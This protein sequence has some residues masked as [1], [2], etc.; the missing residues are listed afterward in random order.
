MNETDKRRT[1][2][3]DESNCEEEVAALLGWSPA[4]LLRAI[5]MHA[6]EEDDDEDVDKDDQTPPHTAR[7]TPSQT[8]IRCSPTQPWTEIGAGR[9]EQKTAET[10]RPTQHLHQHQQSR[11]PSAV[12]CSPPPLVGKHVVIDLTDSPSPPPTLPHPQQQQQRQRHK[13][14]RAPPSPPLS[15]V[16]LDLS[17]K[18]SRYSLVDR[19]DN[20]KMKCSAQRESS[21][22][23]SS[24]SSS[25]GSSGNRNINN[26]NTGLYVIHS[27]PLIDLCRPADYITVVMDIETTGFSPKT[28]HIIQLAA[29]ANWIKPN[30]LWTS[31]SFSEYVTLPSPSSASSSSRRRKKALPHHITKLTGITSK[32]LQTKGMAFD[33]MWRKF[34]SWLQA[35]A[36]HSPLSGDQAKPIV[37]LAHNGK[38]FDF[39]FLQAALE[40]FQ[41][42]PNDWERRANICCF[43]DTLLILRCEAAWVTESAINKENEENDENVA[44]RSAAVTVTDDSCD[45]YQHLDGIPGSLKSNRHQLR[46]TISPAPPSTAPQSTTTR[47]HVPVVVSKPAKLSLGALH[48]HLFHCEI[49]GAHCAQADVLALCRVLGST[50]LRHTWQAVGNSLQFSRR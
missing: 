11:C 25:N 35:C 40:R 31:D 50:S 49:S 18:L 42:Y 43:L 15:E 3:K 12:R 24:S 32:T 28:D 30:G 39:P 14:S 45:T 46:A 16:M 44:R 17:T 47:S 1:K 2:K 10:I 9:N 4:S 29:R 21:S 33:Q 23:S 41:L 48:E 36:G 26:K 19:N 13:R 37:L 6:R 20:N 38:A 22:S 34:L 7:A 8:T 5:D 27:T